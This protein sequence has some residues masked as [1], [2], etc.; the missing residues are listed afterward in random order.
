ML[1][2]FEPTHIKKAKITLEKNLLLAQEL[3]KKEETIKA[4]T[5]W[6]K[7]KLKFLG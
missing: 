7:I 3:Q 5:W 4:F 6:Q 1:H 2:N